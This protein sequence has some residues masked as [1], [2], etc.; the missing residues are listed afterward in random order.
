MLYAVSKLSGKTYVNF[1]KPLLFKFSPDKVHHTTNK[2]GKTAGAFAPTRILTKA[3][4]AYENTAVL[5]QTVNTIYFKNP[6]GLSAGFDK[7]FELL[8]LLP[9]LGFGFVEGGSLTFHASSG[10][11]KPHYRRLPESKSILVNAGLNNDGVH[12]IVDRIKKQ[13]SLDYPLNISV[14]KTNSSHANTMQKGIN[15]YLQSLK[16]IQK[17]NVGDIITLN[18]SC[19]NAY[20][21]EPFTTPKSLDALLATVTKLTLHQPIF[22]KMPIDK[23]WTEF[24]QLL[25]I[26]IKYKIAGV[27]IGNLAKDRNNTAI[28]NT[29]PKSWQGNLSG[30]PTTLLSNELIHQTYRHYGNK[31]T[32]IGV[33]GIFNAQDTYEKIKH[34]ASLVELITGLIFEGPQLIGQ[35]NHNLIQLL[36]DD[37]YTNI[38]Q[39]VGAYHKKPNYQ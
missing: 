23:P 24:D 7:D 15:D 1:A 26:I 4:F 31:L 17:A 11:P 13:G 39:A 12:T 28:K 9:N 5:G 16:V 36:K 29:I 18:I 3:V 19:P 33:G 21:G 38:S 35:I 8:R 22:I 27:T 20:G 37:G 25:K 30:K 2:I 32:I 10:N 6:V 34:G 14:A